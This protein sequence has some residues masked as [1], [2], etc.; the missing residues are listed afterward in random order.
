[1]AVP[2][3]WARGSTSMVYVPVTGSV[4]VSRN[5]VGVEKNGAVSDAPLGWRIV[6][7]APSL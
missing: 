5:P 3:C 7:K 2:V 4:N 6:K 1:M